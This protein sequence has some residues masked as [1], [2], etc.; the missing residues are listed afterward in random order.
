[1]LGGFFSTAT[2]LLSACTSAIA[3]ALVLSVGGVS[4]IHWAVALA[5]TATTACLAAERRSDRNP[6]ARVFDRS[7]MESALGREIFRARRYHRPFATLIFDLS[8]CSPE[9]ST[10]VATEVRRLIRKT[11]EVGFWDHQRLLLVLSESHAHDAASLAERIRRE[12]G[13]T[14]PSGLAEY[15]ESDSIGTLVERLQAT[16]GESAPAPSS[17]PPAPA[18]TPESP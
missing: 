4:P 7:E 16:L 15:L 9:T 3:W 5:A 8:R 6:P 18:V 2:F 13:E 1:M 12:L 14:L 11:D 17:T 10:R